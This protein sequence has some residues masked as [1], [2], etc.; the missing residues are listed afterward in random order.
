MDYKKE[1]IFAD[2]LQQQGYKNKRI[3]LIDYEEVG[4]GYY[5]V[6]FFEVNKHGKAIGDITT[7]YIDG[8][9]YGKYQEVMDY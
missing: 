1:K 6:E 7:M 5:A 3:C 2:F 4:S 9:D 8:V